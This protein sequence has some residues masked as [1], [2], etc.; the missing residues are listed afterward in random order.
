MSHA[1]DS[2]SD[3]GTSSP[4]VELLIR[5]TGAGEQ[6]ALTFVLHGRDPALEIT[7]EEFGPV[8]LSMDVQAY[9]RTFLKDIETLS[10]RDEE[11]RRIS[12]RRLATKGANLFK[13]LPEGL[14]LRLWELQG[15]DRMLQILSDEP[16]I[17]WELVKLQ[18][19]GPNGWEQGPFLCEAFIV[20]R[21][22]RGVRKAALRLPMSRIA[23]IVPRN[24][25]LPGAAR[26]H[27]DLLA[28]AG[29]GRDVVEIV[30][31]F[32]DV[33]EA[34]SSGTYDGWH[35]A[36][37][38]ANPGADPDRWELW[39][40]KKE[41]LRPEDLSEAGDLGR[42]RPWIFLNACNTGR[43]GLSI[44]GLGGWAKQFLDSG[45][46]A[47]LGTYWEIPDPMA[48]HF[49]S[50][51]YRRIFAGATVGEAVHQ[52]RRELRDAAP[53]DPTWL[54]YTIFAHPLAVCA[55]WPRDVEE[56]SSRH[57]EARESTRPA[58]TPT[59]PA[60]QLRT[61][62]IWT[63]LI[64]TM[65]LLVVVT[66]V[67]LLDH[68]GGAGSLERSSTTESTPRTDGM[69]PQGSSANAPPSHPSGTP[70][71]GDHQTSQD[72]RERKSIPAV[73]VDF[74]ITAAPGVPKSTIEGALRS[75]AAEQGI[76]G[77][78]LELNVEAPR[79][80]PYTQDGLDW[81]T[82]RLVA[83]GR[84]RSREGRSLDL[85]AVRAVNSQADGAIACDEAAK[86]LARTVVHRLV[87]SLQQGP[88]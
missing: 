51:V 23:L 57:D 37:H 19:R 21:W 1:F 68:N 82:C 38:G 65:L 11:Q 17:P 86:D 26:E 59:P 80:S 42:C 88:G 8:A 36:G 56:E 87:A 13:L 40:E 33:V 60:P 15:R 58:E 20:T 12:Q 18:K 77:W 27:E 54:A 39:L 78:M 5:T 2:V 24:P 53:G 64:V 44:A 75:G 67:W 61:R 47:F 35:F 50:S 76:S 48:R 72:R 30:P 43:A 31:R 14:R 83:H 84:A 79:I 41:C 71:S 28:L 73:G 16:Y 70:N 7:Y 66:T 3:S 81:E 4:D 69:P 45:A 74:A 49:A 29:P 25:D 52:T 6:T 62:R 63:A 85:G 46:G 22:L 34:L 32:L 10:T 9:L 55:P